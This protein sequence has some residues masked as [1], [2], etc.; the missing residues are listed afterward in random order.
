MALADVLTETNIVTLEPISELNERDERLADSFKTYVYVVEVSEQ[1]FAVFLSAETDTAHRA[2]QERYA[3]FT[4]VL[5]PTT[6]PIYELSQKNP[7][8]KARPPLYHGHKKL[9]PGGANLMINPPNSTEALQAGAYVIYVNANQKP[10]RFVAEIKTAKQGMSVE[11]VLSSNNVRGSL[12]L[13]VRTILSTDEKRQTVRRE[14]EGKTEYLESVFADAKIDLSFRYSDPVVAT[15]EQLLGESFY[16]DFMHNLLEANPRDVGTI[17][18]YLYESTMT[19]IFG[20]STH[21]PGP[22]GV[23]IFN[24]GVF[25]L[26]QEHFFLG[27]DP[28]RPNQNPDI[29]D[30]DVTTAHEVGHYL[31]LPHVCERDHRDFFSDTGCDE[32]NLMRV[33]DFIHRG[34]PFSPNQSL[35]MLR[36]P[37]IELRSR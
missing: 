6:E 4:K 36:Q 30:M 1:V 18:V 33:G 20:W 34:H 37:S 35:Y 13:D 25:V 8:V 31:G 3:V 10:T 9:I 12:T 5:S 16:I 19:G 32:R 17:G 22:I 15:E 21:M 7:Q 11:Q 24:A 26:A 23:D 29:E 14:F 27:G 28:S 2:Q